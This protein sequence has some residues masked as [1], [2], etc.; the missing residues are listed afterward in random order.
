M[1]KHYRTISKP[2]IIS[3]I[4]FAIVFEIIFVGGYVAVGH[5]CPSWKL[6]A[7]TFFCFLAFLALVC[8]NVF[9]VLFLYIKDIFLYIKEILVLLGLKI[10]LGFLHLYKLILR[11]LGYVLLFICLF[12]ILGLIFLINTE[13][14]MSL[15]VIFS[16]FLISLTATFV[17]IFLIYGI[18]HPRLY[19][20]DNFEVGRDDVLR[21]HVVNKSLF[22]A[23]NL[24]ANLDFCRND[25]KGNVYIQTIELNRD[26]VGFINNRFGDNPR[27]IVFKS[28]GSFSWT[29]AKAR[30]DRIRFRIVA[31]HQISNVIREVE[32]ECKKENIIYLKH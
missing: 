19:I 30:Y 28:R 21:I 16:S 23:Y 4:V 6:C 2:S 5:T 1:E 17:G 29:G 32:K 15:L 9:C 14:S 24:K 3:V 31:T 13:P 10:A 11:N 22:K 26:T 8:S 12:A 20:K 7:L 18:A 25:E 27:A